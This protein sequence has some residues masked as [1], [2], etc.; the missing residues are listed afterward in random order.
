MVAVRAKGGGSHKPWTLDES[1][2]HYC[3]A[4]FTW[5]E[6]ME[7]YPLTTF[8]FLAWEVIS[9]GRQLY[10]TSIFAKTQTDLYLT[11]PIRKFCGLFPRYQR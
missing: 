6:G 10:L 2:S 11:R 5:W 4:G 8:L 7:S 1:T 9:S 3:G